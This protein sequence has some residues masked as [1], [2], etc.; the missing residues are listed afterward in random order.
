MTARNAEFGRAVVRP[1][2]LV[3]FILSQFFFVAV[4]RHDTLDVE[5]WPNKEP[6]PRIFQTR[7]IAQSFVSR[8]NNLSRIDIF[9]GT[10]DQILRSDLIFR[11]YRGGPK[12]R[13]VAE[14]RVPGSKIRNNLFTPIE[15]PSVKNSNGKIFTFVL[16]MP[17][18]AKKDGPSVWMGA[19]DVYTQG[20]SFVNGRP[21]PADCVFR[22]YSRRTVLAEWERISRGLPGSL[23]NPFVLALAAML[24]EIAAVAV[25]WRVLGLFFENGKA[26][27]A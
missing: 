7:T 12:G 11:L 15:F 24:F 9:F 19:G 2:L 18:A 22:T 3:A 25:F 16:S 10:Y 23:K 17:G 20:K 26:P 5:V 8:I 21:L 4:P 14:V 27:D 13:G 6:S 1:L